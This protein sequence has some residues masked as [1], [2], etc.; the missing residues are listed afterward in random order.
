MPR[1][2]WVTVLILSLVTGGLISLGASSHPDGLE[3]VAENHGLLDRATSYIAGLIPDYSV[4][5]IPNEYLAAAVAGLI[6]TIVTFSVLCG[7][8]YLLT[9]NRS[10]ASE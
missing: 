7:I 1:N 9:I 5:G 3:R 2:T 4:A 10:R 6:G 8:G